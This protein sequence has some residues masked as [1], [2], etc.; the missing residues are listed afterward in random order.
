MNISEFDKCSNC[1]ACYSICHCEAI[2]VEENGLFYTPVVDTNKCTQCGECVKVCPVNNKIESY[3]PIEAYAGWHNEDDI[4]MSSSSGGVF[5]GMAQSVLSD[6]GVVYGA[7]YSEDCREVVIDSSDNK[8]LTCLQ[9]SKYV[10][11][12]ISNAFV[13]IKEELEKKRKV[14][15]C[16]APCQVAGLKRFLGQNYSNLITCDFVCGGFPSHRLY[17]EYLDYLEKKYK[18]KVKKVDFRPKTHGWRRYAVL[19]E[20]E[21]G[22]KYNTLGVEDPF[23]RSFLYG[24][25]TVRDYCLECKFSD[26]HQSD[27]TIADF[28][29]FEKLSD[30]KNEDG[31]S[32]V[33]CNTEKGVSFVSEMKSNYCFDK[34][35]VNTVLYNHKKTHTSEEQVE[36]H[37]KFLKQTLKYGF[38][39][40]YKE[41][42]K[43]SLKVKIKN[44]IARSIYKR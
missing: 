14:L 24:K 40:A 5:Y 11:S 18:S 9:K 39:Y 2:S 32:L 26:E 4:V 10:E 7:A 16:G 37:N 20:F 6:D 34:L 42:F 33:V 8:A 29:L 13:D 28:W 31:I 15:F 27:I 1:G 12:K 25:Y 17:T 38:L 41:Y 3:T 44:R 36:K 21:N 35:D 43:D 19:V 22:K 30:L 23:L